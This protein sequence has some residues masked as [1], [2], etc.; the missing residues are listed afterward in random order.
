MV[1]PLSNLHYCLRPN[2]VRYFLVYYWKQNAIILY[3][4]FFVLFNSFN[5]LPSHVLLA[6]LHLCLSSFMR[7]TVGSVNTTIPITWNLFQAK[8]VSH[9]RPVRSEALQMEPSNLKQRSLQGT[10]YNVEYELECS[11]SSCF[12]PISSLST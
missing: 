3:A 10:R 7:N 12:K 11:F 2:Q 5:M 4:S 9:S 1:N 6:C 8:A